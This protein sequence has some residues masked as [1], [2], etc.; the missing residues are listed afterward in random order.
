M[1]RQGL[2]QQLALLAIFHV[3][4][5][6]ILHKEDVPLAVPSQVA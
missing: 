4:S 6:L 1:V 3:V 5:A 2:S